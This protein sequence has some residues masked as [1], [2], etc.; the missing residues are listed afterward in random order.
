MNQLEL[1]NY[2]RNQKLKHM[3][4]LG[5]NDYLDA[6]IDSIKSHP[7]KFPFCSV[8]TTDDVIKLLNDVKEKVNNN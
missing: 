2:L 8:Y 6:V 5:L 1:D 3:N 4:Q 7:N